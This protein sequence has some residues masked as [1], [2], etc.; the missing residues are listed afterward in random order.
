MLKVYLVFPN[1]CVLWKTHVVFSKQKTVH[2]DIL[3]PLSKVDLYPMKT[4]KTKQGQVLVG[5]SILFVY[6]GE[7][8]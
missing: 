3:S 4:M 1:S 2:K 6:L 8:I 7:N 5:T